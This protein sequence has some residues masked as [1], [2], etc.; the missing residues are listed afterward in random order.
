MIRSFSQWPAPAFVRVAF[1][2]ARWI[3][4]FRGGPIFPNARQDRLT[5]SYDDNARS[6]NRAKSTAIMDLPTRS[7]YEP[8]NQYGQDHGNEKHSDFHQRR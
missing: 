7:G 8:I 6:F 1:Y 2:A 3:A 4:P 5:I